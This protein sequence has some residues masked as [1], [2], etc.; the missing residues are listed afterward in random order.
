MVVGGGVRS[1][2]KITRRNQRWQDRRGHSYVPPSDR[3][4]VVTNGLC[5]A[6]KLPAPEPRPCLVHTVLVMAPSLQPCISFQSR[7]P[8][9]AFGPWYSHLLTLFQTGWVL[10]ACSSPTEYIPNYIV[11]LFPVMSPA[12]T[13]AQISI[14]SHLFLKFGFCLNT[15]NQKIASLHNQVTHLQWAVLR[16]WPQILSWKKALTREKYY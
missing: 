11:S 8:A 7:L 4:S 9:S 15:S 14:I 1:K 3:I 10:F 16:N 12:L 13:D 2:R 5:A 6:S